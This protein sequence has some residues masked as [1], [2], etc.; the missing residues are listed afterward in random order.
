MRCRLL[1]LVVWAFVG[2]GVVVPAQAQQLSNKYY[3][4]NPQSLFEE[5]LDFAAD[6]TL[7]YR[8]YSH[9]PIF[10]RL[11]RYGFSH[12]A[13]DRRGEMSDSEVVRL[14]A[15]NITSPLEEW[16]DYNLLSVLR[17]APMSGGYD[18]YTSPTPYGADLRSEWFTPHPSL[19]K[20][21]SRLKV[22]YAE[23][24]YRLGVNYSAVGRL[25][26]QW[27]YS[28]AVGVRG[29][30]D[31]HI[32]GLFS[33]EAYV[34]LAAESDI[35]EWQTP[36]GDIKG[37]LMVAFVLAPLERAMR[38]WNT[39]ETFELTANRHYNSS[40]G[41]Q[42]GKV[43]SARVRR[44]LV[45]M[46][47]GAYS[48]ENQLG[49]VGATL[50]AMVRGGRKSR[51]ALDWNNAASPLPD[52]YGYL[53]SGYDDPE[54]A[55]EAEKVWRRGD[56]DYTQIG[57]DRLYDINRRSERGAVYALM[58]DREELFS[59]EVSLTAGEG[60]RRVVG[61]EVVDVEGLSG[62]VTLGYHSR[63][64]HDEFSDLLGAQFA[65]EGFDRVDYAVERYGVEID[66]AWSSSGNYG[67]VA[68]CGS[69]GSH[70]L[71]FANPLT[72][73]RL[74]LRN[75]SSAAL[76]ATWQYRFGTQGDVSAA[77]YG[78]L[79]SPHYSEFV[80]APE[81]QA[82]LNPYARA[83]ENYGVEIGGEWR[84]GRVRTSASLWANITH[85]ECRVEH[86]WNDI[87]G[88]YSA[89][90]AGGMKS[91]RAGVEIDAGWYVSSQWSVEGALSIG[92]W[93]WTDD[94]V[95]DIVTTSTAEVLAEHTTLR[96]KGVRSSSSPSLLVAV[97]TTWR[98]A[99]GWSVSLEA[100]IAARRWV[101]PSLF[102][103]SDYLLVRDLSPEERA[104][105]T[106]Q[107]SLGVAPNF[108]LMLY[109]RVGRV[110]VSLSVRNLLNNVAKYDSYQPSRMRITD[111]E[112]AQAY[113]PHPTKSQYTYPRHTYITVSYDF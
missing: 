61:G 88:V 41:Y 85:N 76:K 83:E 29:G 24:N 49:I 52:W 107:P 84:K 57:W 44:E 109:H 2:A 66:E 94:A 48:L 105:F 80:A 79:R 98:P 1:V 95:A 70:T 7:Y 17:R 97:K 101:E 63:R 65:S 11:T 73:S 15:H 60:G 59:A 31:A 92:S 54:L 111:K 20:S 81:E 28:L 104:A 13:F 82:V 78:S 36:Y 51:S 35:G 69:L 55:A 53:P 46:L 26:E 77:L 91:L 74:R 87:D 10:E 3:E 37:R 19:V 34:W 106:T 22:Q 99:N 4:E 100:D 9:Q 96:L 108:S 112:Y 102:F 75:Q 5:L 50:S 89:L 32:E 86:F 62:G 25:N 21:A 43:R 30:R 38:S 27:R 39:D 90:M 40:W 93:K 72:N 42:Q 14:G 45:P 71:K 18:L 6:T 68:V 23:R 67:S 64:L 110:G 8:T 58:E 16:T 56:V 103:C 33:R 12:V 47:Y 113:A